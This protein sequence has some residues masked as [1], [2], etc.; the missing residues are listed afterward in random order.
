MLNTFYIQIFLNIFQK[1][2][3]TLNHLN[4]YK[5]LYETDRSNNLSIRSDYM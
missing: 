1:Q 4:N 5:K 2:K 3:F